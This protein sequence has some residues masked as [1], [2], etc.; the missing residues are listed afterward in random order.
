MIRGF[1]WLASSTWRVFEAHP[2]CG[3]DQYHFPF[4][5]WIILS[6]MD[7][8]HFGFPFIG[9]CV[10]YIS[11]VLH[12]HAHMCVVCIPTNGIAKSC[13]NSMFS[14]YRKMPDC[15]PEWLHHF[16]I[17]LA[18]CDIPGSPQPSPAVL[19]KWFWHSSHWVVRSL[20]P[21]LS[22]PL[23]FRRSLWL[24]QPTECNGND[25]TWLL[26]PDR[27]HTLH[28]HPAL[29]ECLPWEPSRHVVRKPKLAQVKRPR[30]D[31]T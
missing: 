23:E 31:V 2:C 6:S 14:L 27:N 1:L 13:G 30:G 21:S 3:M 25:P 15:F 28:F 24:Y 16:K 17:P 8:P 4:Y 9:F 10:M 19:T 22:S 11:F 20:P 29:L 12:M 7:L 26:R 18:V 5:G